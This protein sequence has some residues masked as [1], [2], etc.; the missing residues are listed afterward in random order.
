MLKKQEIILIKS[1]SECITNILKTIKQ[2]RQN[3]DVIF[4]DRSTVRG[5]CVRDY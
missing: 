2:E 3:H 5:R 4:S 1:L